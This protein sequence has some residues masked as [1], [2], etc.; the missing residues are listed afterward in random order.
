ML[1]AFVEIAHSWL[2]EK[3]KVMLNVFNDSDLG[4]T[5]DSKGTVRS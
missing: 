4:A 1:L 2:K 5:L 3:F